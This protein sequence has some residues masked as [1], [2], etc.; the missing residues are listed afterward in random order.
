MKKEN[1]SKQKDEENGEDGFWEK[2]AFAETLSSE[3]TEERMKTFHKKHDEDMNFS[4]KKCK[5]KISAHN[6]DWHDG[7]C[8]DCFDKEHFPDVKRKNARRKT[9]RGR[10]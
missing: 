8:D 10:V 1:V 2:G 4:C 3:D 6:K 9:A 5:D 7:M